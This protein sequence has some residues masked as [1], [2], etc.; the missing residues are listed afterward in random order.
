MGT[1]QTP[2]SPPATRPD[3][4]IDLSE[5]V[6]GEEDPGASIDIAGTPKEPAADRKPTPAAGKERPGGG[7]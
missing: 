7:T 2:K 6:A 1:P 4:P 5:S 3:D